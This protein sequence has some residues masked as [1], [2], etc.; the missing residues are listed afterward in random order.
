MCVEFLCLDIFVNPNADAGLDEFTV[1]QLE[2]VGVMIS[3]DQILQPFV[4]RADI[5]L[6]R[7]YLGNLKHLLVEPETHLIWDEAYAP[8]VTLTL[9]APVVRVDGKFTGCLY[10]GMRPFVTDTE[11]DGCLVCYIVLGCFVS[12]KSGYSHSLWILGLFDKV[13]YVTFDVIIDRA[14]SGERGTCLGMSCQSGYKSW[15]FYFLIEI[16]DKGSSGKM[17]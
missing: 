7:D 9:A 17:R 15:V 3:E 13:E 6:T 14:V 12:D 16:A 4:G 5:E 8:F 10:V 11:I 2:G 1:A